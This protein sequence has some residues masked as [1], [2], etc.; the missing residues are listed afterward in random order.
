MCSA[1]KNGQAKALKASLDADLPEIPSFIMDLLTTF[2]GF[3]DA[4]NDAI[5][6]DLL[7]ALEQTEERTILYGIIIHAVNVNKNLAVTLVEVA[8]WSAGHIDN[9]KEDET[10]ETACHTHAA[11]AGLP[12]LVEEGIVIAKTFLGSAQ[13][14]WSTLLHKLIP[15][16]T[17]VVALTV[18]V[19]HEHPLKYA[20]SKKGEAMKIV[21]GKLD[22]ILEHCDDAC[23]DPK[24]WT[25]IVAG[26]WLVPGAEKDTIEKNP[27][28]QCFLDACTALQDAF[29]KLIPRVNALQ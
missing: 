25:Q 4:F 1:D 21:E 10:F 13:S 8:K 2:F 28:N 29:K 22:D 15:Q 26:M 12:A 18:K 23:D 27:Y 20:K 16:I 5:I 7:Q 14:C 6:H 19:A 3:D 17:E 24:E 11:K 9:I